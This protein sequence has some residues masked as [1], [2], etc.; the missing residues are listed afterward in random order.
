[1]RTGGVCPHC[2]R[3]SSIILFD[4]AENK[5]PRGE[6]HQSV[7]YHTLCSAGL[8][9]PCSAW[10]GRP[11][12]LPTNE[13]GGALPESCCCCMQDAAAEN[14][15]ACKAA[16]WCAGRVESLPV[17]KWSWGISTGSRQDLGEQRQWFL[18]LSIKWSLHPPL[19]HDVTTQSTREPHRCK[20][21]KTTTKHRSRSDSPILRPGRLSVSVSDLLVGRCGGGASHVADTST[22]SSFL[23]HGLASVASMAIHIHPTWH[24]RAWDGMGHGMTA[25]GF[26]ELKHQAARAGSQA[27]PCCVRV[28]LS[29]SASAFA[30][31]YLPAPPLG[32]PAGS[33]HCRLV[34]VGLVV[35][36]VVNVWL[37][38]G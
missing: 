31:Y 22:M 24:G 3:L 21:K 36:V 25:S 20:R 17:R 14:I 2:A 18:A 13:L 27:Y 5:I 35:V 4:R 33:G 1:M 6:T 8:P 11:N 19:R 23:W 16:V 7:R 15:N 37:P 38:L 30:E 12:E 26:C 28:C 34:A 32:R 9:P 10:P 29:A